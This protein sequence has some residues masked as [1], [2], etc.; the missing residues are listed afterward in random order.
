MLSCVFSYVRQLLY[1]KLN[2]LT[3]HCFTG[4]SNKISFTDSKHWS[5]KLL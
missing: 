4:G 3:G 5:C 1:Y 2:K